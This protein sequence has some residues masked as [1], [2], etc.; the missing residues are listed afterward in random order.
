[1]REEDKG[2]GQ[3]LGAGVEGRGTCQ[4]KWEAGGPLNKGWGKA[5]SLSAPHLSLCLMVNPLSHGSPS[6][7]R[8]LR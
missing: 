2:G 1:M 3:D 4:V 5:V 7:G 8:K 6:Q